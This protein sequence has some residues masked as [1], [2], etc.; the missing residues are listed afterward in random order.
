MG[1]I[2]I[3]FHLGEVAGSDLYKQH[4]QRVSKSRSIHSFI[5]SGR[6][7]WKLTIPINSY[8][9]FLPCAPPTLND[10]G[11]CR[12]KTKVSQ[13]S[14]RSKLDGS[15]R[16]CGN[17]WRLPSW[18]GRTGVCFPLGRGGTATERDAL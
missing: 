8:S 9:I 1:G 5:Q 2:R 14:P 11:I 10:D 17:F 16:H 13:M 12:C 15:C 3:L 18:Y 4:G 6:S 7:F